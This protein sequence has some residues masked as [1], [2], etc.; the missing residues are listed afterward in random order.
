MSASA[1]SIQTRNNAAASQAA[2][3]TQQSKVSSNSKAGGFDNLFASALSSLT[4]Q[5]K[6]STIQEE[7]RE[8]LNQNSIK[9]SQNNSDNLALA[10]QQ[11]ASEAAVWAQ[12][13]W[14]TAT[15]A[16]SANASTSSL[17]VQ[18]AQS[19]LAD[20]SNTQTE[21]SGSEQT[22]A[23]KD[24]P[25]E[26]EKVKDSTAAQTDDHTQA[27]ASD[28]QQDSEPA[29]VKDTGTQTANTVVASAATQTLQDQATPQ[30]D[31]TNGLGQ[32]AVALK[33]DTAAG[34]SNDAD[35][36]SKSKSAPDVDLKGPTSAAQ[37]PLNTHTTHTT[38]IVRSAAVQ[39][40][41]V[42]QQAQAMSKTGQGTEA[43]VKGL[44]AGDKILATGAS[45][46]ASATGNPAAGLMGLGTT[47]TGL[48]GE[49]LI[50]TPV[51]QPGFVKELAQQVNWTLGKNMSTV[52]IRV[53]PESFGPMNM[54]LVQKGQEIHLVIR[55]QDD[56]SAAIMTQA[57]HG[58]K[59]ALAQS[60]LQL[61][62]VQIHGS[63]ADA[64]NAFAN[65]QQQAQGQQQANGGKGQRQGGQGQS[66]GESA[67]MDSAPKAVAPKIGNN[68]LDLFA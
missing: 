31:T 58:L 7:M 18:S 67:D 41:Q 57:V 25:A 64:Q 6:L 45:A 8:A 65:L 52:D 14:M 29:N 10:G 55:T 30:T 40:M 37:Q 51:N 22:A 56:Q 34:G 62:Q 38:Q 53:N 17:P 42:A 66:D 59:E 44:Q 35:P 39:A 28:N 20:T 43:D 16:Q 50:K 32:N 1:Q 54:R 12:R 36:L 24:K 63:A 49:A 2:Q 4:P 48:A 47:R 23:N 60:G 5:A 27:K 19:K 61:G 11:Q 33:A 26:G 68:G 46:A 13:S 9:K 21:K 15:P 3:A